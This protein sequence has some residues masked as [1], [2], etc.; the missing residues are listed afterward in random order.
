MNLCSKC[1]KQPRLENHPAYCR[2][3]RNQYSREWRSKNP[4]RRTPI[5]KEA[6]KKWAKTRRERNRDYVTAAKEGKPCADCGISY[7][8][9]AMQFD[10]AGSKKDM[11]LGRA[12]SQTWSIERLQAEINKC[13]IVCANCHAV[14]TWT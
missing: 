8:A 10:H 4:G 2:D 5:N 11:C 9:V 6:A 14:R 12:A 7:P 13:E 1:Q 3:C